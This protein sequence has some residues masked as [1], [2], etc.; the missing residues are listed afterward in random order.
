M[1]EPGT[2]QLGGQGVTVENGTARLKDGTLAGSILCMNDA[3]KNAMDYFHIDIIKAVRLASLNPAKS[4]KVDDQLGSI[5][6]GKLADIIIFDEQ[7]RLK[8][9]FVNGKLIY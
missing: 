5:A 6:V 1:K 3:V 2:Y 4:I 8:H 7:V 9:A